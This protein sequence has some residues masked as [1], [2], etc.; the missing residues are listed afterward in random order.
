VAVANVEIA[1][2]QR[3][4]YHLDPQLRRSIEEHAVS[5]ARKVYE[6]NGYP[7]D[8]RG[9]PYDLYCRKKRNPSDEIWVEVKGSQ[10]N[11]TEIILTRGA[12]DL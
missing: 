2:A 8:V 6:K 3:Q 7:V 5:V 10:E 12:E 1:R 9:R 11:P 4:G